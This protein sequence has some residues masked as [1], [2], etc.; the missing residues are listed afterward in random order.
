MYLLSV[1]QYDPFLYRWDHRGKWQVLSFGDQDV[2]RYGQ[3]VYE[4]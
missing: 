1:L 2:Q 4:D 3:I